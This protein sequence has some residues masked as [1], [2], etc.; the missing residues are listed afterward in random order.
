[1]DDSEAMNL[2]QMRAFLVGS[3]EVRFAGVRRAEVYAWVERNEDCLY[4]DESRT[5]TYRFSDAGPRN[6]AEGPHQNAAFPHKRL[7]GPQG[8]TVYRQDQNGV[9]RH[10]YGQSVED[11]STT[12]A[13][14]ASTARS[15][16]S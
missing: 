5:S 3:G 15:A 12:C 2:E 4:R 10:F 9:V 11:E 16:A 6:G 14:L 13:E 8:L 7:N 1:M